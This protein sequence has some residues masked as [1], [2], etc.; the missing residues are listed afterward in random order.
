MDKSQLKDFIT[1][2]LKYG[3]A[4][5]IATSVDYSIFFLLVLISNPEIIPLIQAFAYACGVLVNF[6]LRKRFVF[7]LNRSIS[8]T[9]TMSMTFSLIGIGLSTLA[10]YLLTKLTFFSEHLLLTKLVITLTFFIYN[11]YANRFAF[12]NKGVFSSVK[13]KEEADKES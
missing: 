4:S 1:P 3:I 11:F 7:T 5:G 2:K 9:F 13:L 12:E 10:I 8:M 6:I